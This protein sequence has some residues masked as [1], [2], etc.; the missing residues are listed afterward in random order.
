MTSIIVAKAKNNVIGNKNELPW[1]LKGDLRH[2]KELTTGHPVVMGRKTFESIVARLKKPLPDR[3]NIVL[4]R[5]QTFQPIG[6]V[7][8]AHS[9]EEALTMA[10]EDTFVIG[11]ASVYEQALPH[12]DTLYVTEVKAEVEGDTFFPEIKSTEWD[13]VSRESFKKNKD[14]QYPYDIVI[15]ERIK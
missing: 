4:T 6:S 15:Y 8:V 11:G 5:D 1:R 10:G 13:E 12:V 2:F 14:N 9:I 3:R 7:A